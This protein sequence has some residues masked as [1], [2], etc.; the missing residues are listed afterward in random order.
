ME[1][2]VKA[3]TLEKFGKWYN[4][5]LEKLEDDDDVLVSSSKRKVCEGCCRRAGP[6]GCALVSAFCRNSKSRPYYQSP[7]ARPQ[8][9]KA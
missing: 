1:K 9:A 6:L 2:E 8:V 5:Q 7:T 4:K 3:L